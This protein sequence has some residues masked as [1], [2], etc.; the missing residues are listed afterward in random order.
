MPTV[1][2]DA[3]EHDELQPLDYAADVVR[4]EALP[5]IAQAG[6]SGIRFEQVGCE[7]DKRVRWNPFACMQSTCE[8]Y[9][10]RHQRVG[11]AD[12]ERVA[13]PTL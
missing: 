8:G 4:R 10:V 13:L 6:A 2:V 7:I 9:G 11:R 1:W 12:P 3:R 5:P